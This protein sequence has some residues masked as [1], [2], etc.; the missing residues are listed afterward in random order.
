MGA[1]ALKR[2]HLSTFHMEDSYSQIQLPTTMVRQHYSIRS[3]FFSDFHILPC[4]NTLNYD[5]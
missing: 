2:Q 4:S 1:W 5:R 3:I